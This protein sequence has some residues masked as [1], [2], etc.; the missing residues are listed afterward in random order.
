MWEHSTMVSNISLLKSFSDETIYALI[1]NF[2]GHSIVL[3]MFLKKCKMKSKCTVQGGNRRVWGWVCRS[4]N[5][6]RSSQSGPSK[7]L[8]ITF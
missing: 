3:K 1:S 5:G 8:E 4:D 6:R 7:K 2:S